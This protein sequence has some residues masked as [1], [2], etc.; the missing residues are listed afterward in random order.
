MR[1]ICSNRLPKVTLYIERLKWQVPSR[2]DDNPAATKMKTRSPPR[3]R[4]VT[5]VTTALSPWNSIIEPFEKDCTT[6]IELKTLVRKLD[7]QTYFMTGFGPH[8][9]PLS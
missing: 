7:L 1:T 4:T 5:I 6:A 2:N 9:T 8:R 3:F